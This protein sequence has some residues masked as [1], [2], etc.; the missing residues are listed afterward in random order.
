[1]DVTPRELDTRHGSTAGSVC[2]FPFIDTAT[3]KTEMKENTSEEEE[4][5]GSERTQHRCAE[6]Q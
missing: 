1:M 3:W 5:G 6:R 2:S 4:D